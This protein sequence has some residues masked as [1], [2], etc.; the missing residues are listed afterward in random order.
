MLYA[1]DLHIH[2]SYSRATSRE[3]TLPNL[4]ATAQRKGI[5][6]V[7]TGDCVHP[8]WLREIEDSLEE[9]GDGFLRL[10]DDRRSGCAASVPAACRAEARFVPTVEISGI[11]KRDGVVRKVHN[12]IVLP[13]A[14]AA[15][16]LQARLAALGNIQSDGRPILGLDSRDLLEIVLE[17]DPAAIL[18]PAHIWTPRTATRT[19]PAT[20]A[21]SRPGSRPTPR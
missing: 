5:Q 16:R 21:H 18:I 11:Y 14:A 20:C 1:A 8:A 6:L 12:V 19:S 7:G 17:T 4:W 2:S 9:A 3:L 15:R 10:R 13:S